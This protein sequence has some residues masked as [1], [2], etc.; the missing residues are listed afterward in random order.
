MSKRM[1][2]EV[3]KPPAVGTVTDELIDR[4][5]DLQPYAG[6]Y[7]VMPKAFDVATSTARGVEVLLADCSEE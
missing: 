5:S 6:W 1:G 7:I 3:D 2:P 4:R